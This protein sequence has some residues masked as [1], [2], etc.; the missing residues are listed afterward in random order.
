MF[1]FNDAATRLQIKSLVDSYLDVVRT[2]GGIYDYSTI[3]DDSNNTPE[4][5]DQNFGIIDIGVE[6]SRGLQKFINRITILKTGAIAAGGF[7]AV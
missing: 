4:I 2:A 5:I 7:A 6:P 3:M 1:E